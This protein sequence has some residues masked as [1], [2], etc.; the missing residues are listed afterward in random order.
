[1]DEYFFFLNLVVESQ[2]ISILNTGLREFVQPLEDLLFLKS[3]HDCER[4]VVR[5][6]SVEKRRMTRTW[7]LHDRETDRTR[8]LFIRMDKLGFIYNVFL[9]S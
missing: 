8:R 6:P 9:K 1:M 5:P 2:R 7:M 3:R 4:H